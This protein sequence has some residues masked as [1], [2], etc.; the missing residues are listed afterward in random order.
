VD[1]GGPTNYGLTLGFLQGL[2]DT[3]GDG[4]LEGDIN[5]DNLVNVADV[6]AMTLGKAEEI[7]REFVWNSYGLGRIPEQIP[8]SHALE[9]IV[10]FGPATGIRILQR[11][12]RACGCAEISVDGK[13]GP[14]TRL[15]LTEVPVM[16]QDAAIRAA[17]VGQYRLLA[18]VNPVKY[19][20]YLNGWLVRAYDPWRQ[21]EL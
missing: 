3:D 18:A 1:T 19:G 5:R 6:R 14:F 2:P 4:F 7:F 12:L 16:V 15:R 17:Q 8:A 9:L 10:N 20:E 13:L 11:A 21:G